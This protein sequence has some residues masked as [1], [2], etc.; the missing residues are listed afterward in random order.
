M[1]ERN[2][3]NE[4]RSAMVVEL[5][6]GVDPVSTEGRAWLSRFRRHISGNATSPGPKGLPMHLSGYGAVVADSITGVYATFPRVVA[7]VCCVVLLIMG[8]SF[9]SVLLAVRGIVTIGTTIVF[10]TGLA[11]LVYCDGMLS[12]LGSFGAFDETPGMVWCVAPTVFPL[13]VGIALDYDIFLVGRIVELHEAGLHTRDSILLGLAST[14]TIITAAGSIQAL[15][16]FALMMSPILVLN[17]LGFFL[18]VAVL[19]DTFVVR[20]LLVP[21]IMFWFGDAMLPTITRKR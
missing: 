6:L 19:F 7:I 1:A 5:I 16:F 20:G 2:F 15:A 8:A 12:F 21:S 13:L 18:F 11:K 9:R 4:D 17:Q 3:I 14:G 10:V